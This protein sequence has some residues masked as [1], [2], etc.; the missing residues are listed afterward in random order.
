LESSII[1][2]FPCVIGAAEPAVEIK[3]E[4]MKER[5][6]DVAYMKGTAMT[7]RNYYNVSEKLSLLKPDTDVVRDLEFV[8]KKLDLLPGTAY[9]FRVAAYGPDLCF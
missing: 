7:V 2:L 8:K 3:A 1:S 6:M 4:D 5:W 9:K